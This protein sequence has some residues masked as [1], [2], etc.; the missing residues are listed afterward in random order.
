ME[1]LVPAKMEKL[2]H[3]LFSQYPIGQ[4]PLI[5]CGLEFFDQYVPVTPFLRSPL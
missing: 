5:I 2:Y 4:E 3:L 1:I